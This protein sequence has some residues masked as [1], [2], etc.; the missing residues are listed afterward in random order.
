MTTRP[1]YP[2]RELPGYVLRRASSAMMG[3][4]AERLAPLGLRHVEATILLLLNENPGMSQSALGRELGIK[5]AN[6]TPLS[7]Q[8]ER[9]GWLIRTAS[10]GRSL[11]LELSAA[12][13]ELAAKV[14]AVIYGYERELMSL[15]PE[16]HRAHLLPALI[17]LWDEDGAD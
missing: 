16:E 14:H 5:R 4:L 13:K 1:I 10:D 12:G 8:M 17:A 2:L 7:A 6:M 11:G 3:R 15:V 9:H